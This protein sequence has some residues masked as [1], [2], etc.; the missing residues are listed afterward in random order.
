MTT[1]N[2]EQLSLFGTE[3]QPTLSKK[4]VRKSSAT[5]TSSN[6]T[7][8]NSAAKSMK[9]QKIEVDLDFTIHYA[10][11]VFQV[12]DFIEDVPESG[13]IS[14]PQLRERME[15]QF[16]ELTEQRTIWDYDIEAKRLMPYAS[17]TTK[18]YQVWE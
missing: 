9:D 17:G 8:V 2:I 3:Y 13:T 12:S 7:T 4:I 14:L 5:T 15:Q 6:G 16:F 10:T 11:H 1:N 18:G